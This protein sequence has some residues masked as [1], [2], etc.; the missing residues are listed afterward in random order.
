MLHPKTKTVFA[1]LAALAL[2]TQ[3]LFAAYIPSAHDTKLPPD[4]ITYTTADP[5]DFA[6][7]Y[8]T[9]NLKYYFKDERDVIAIVDKRNGYTW[10]T[11][12]DIPYNKDL[13][14]ACKLV[15]DE[16]KINCEPTED[17]LN[18]TYT[19]IAN[20]LITVEYYD[21]SNSIKRLS[22]ASLT[23]VK[24]ALGM[25]NGDA[26]H[27][28]LDVNFTTIQLKVSVHITFD[29]KGMELEIRDD[30]ITGD[31][32]T[33]LAAIQL[34]PFFGASGGQK[35]YWDPDKR[36]FKREVP[37]E[38]IEGYVL[39]PDGPGALIRFV[40]RNIGLSPYIGDVYGANPA[41][42]TYYYSSEASYF[43]FKSPS[44]PVY[45]IAHGNRQAAYVGFATKGAAYM[46][47]YVSPEEDITY[48]TYAYP[49]FE[50][51]NIFHQVYNKRGDGYFT[52]M[53]E[54][55]HFDIN[56]RYEFL[57]ND[58]DRPA[59][60][61]GMALTYRD[62]L[63]AHDAL[64][65]KTQTNDKIGIRLD[66]VMAD[67]KKS[68][69]GTQDVIVTTAKDVSNILSDLHDQNIENISS[70]L[71]GWA[72][73]GITSGHPGTT[74]WSGSIGSKSAF[75]N[76][77]EL[78]SG[79]GYDVSFSQDYVNIHKT[80]VNYST[81]AARHINSWYIEYRLRGEYPVN[82]FGIAKPTKSAAWIKAQTT[83]LA[84]LDVGSFTIE[85]ISS[86]LTSDF[87]NG[88]TTLEETITLYQNAL[89]ALDPTQ[90]VAMTNPNDYLWNYVDR[91]LN[92]PVYSTQFLVETDTV[93]FLQLVLNQSMEMYAPYSNFSFYTPKDVLRMIDYNTY[94]S[95]VLSQDPAYN[96][97]LTNANR[98]YSTEYTEYK[99]L[100]VSIYKDVDRSLSEVIGA[101]WIDRQVLEN[102]VILNVYDNGK[103]ILI[104]YTESAVTINGKI[105]Q[106]MS[107]TVIRE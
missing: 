20:S 53:D 77:I 78:A 46:T 92:T 60:Y 5:T 26:N 15:P 101:K 102:G 43:P 41:E 89:A 106:A 38:M 96:L 17:R 97:A 87:D 54:R 70:G 66:F 99:S 13:E 73:G 107:A 105:F 24:S 33:V 95:F 90:T 8:E 48:Y 69:F 21:D 88:T 11:G 29:S 93:P 94:P 103:K 91:Y 45:G 9:E 59:D 6:L 36:G 65:L 72:S 2:S 4:T 84:K 52:T 100:I 1:G 68:V 61:V 79:F 28:R 83:A 76:L 14:A 27:Y 39:V 74:E 80:Q 82:L 23:G 44:M 37:N 104:N 22:S 19:G 31:G 86:V 12:I 50:Y 62:Y 64:T 55:R 71:L 40:D 42:S 16:E 67:I 85:G 81:S 75:T 3:A 58:G 32:Q 35:L 63:L 49:R 7:L 51:N 34:M 47:L 98:Y 25:V 10:K 18:T 56:M 57:A 30:E